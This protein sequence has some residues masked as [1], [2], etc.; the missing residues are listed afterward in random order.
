MHP[1][2]PAA[3]L[4]FLV[5]DQIAQ[6]ALDPYDI[7]F[8]LSSGC[9]I[10][11]EHRIEHVDERGVVH[12][13]DCMSGSR[14]ALYLH[15]LLQHPVSSVDTEPLCLSLTFKNGAV[16]RVFSEIGSYECG[17]IFPSEGS[18]RGFIVF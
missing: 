1:F 2:P 3:D 15:Q 4:Q 16:L 7:Q 14:E 13:H 17:Q 9:R 11:V 5:G 6:I 12:L 8:R 10:T 18:G